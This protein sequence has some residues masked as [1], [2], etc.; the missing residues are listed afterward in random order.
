MEE[1]SSFVVRAVSVADVLS[2][3]AL[4][5]TNKLGCQPSGNVANFAVP[6]L[7]SVRVPAPRANLEK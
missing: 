3:E 1:I 4:F 5:S 7:I 2:G 6:L